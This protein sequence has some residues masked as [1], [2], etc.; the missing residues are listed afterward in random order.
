MKQNSEIGI[1]SILRQ[2]IS[3]VV[4]AVTTVLFLVFGSSWLSGLG[5]NLFSV[6]LFVWIFSVMLWS[7]FSVVRHADFL[8]I[9]LGEPYGTL[10][11]TISVISIEVIMISSIMLTGENN[12]TVG[13]DMMFGVFMI[14]LNA[15]IGLSLLVGGIRHIEQSY[16]FQGANTFLA[17]LIP[18]AVL[19]LILPNYTTPEGTG[20]FSKIQMVFIS[21][22][23]LGLYGAFLIIQ[24]MRHS[25]FFISADDNCTS[26]YEAED[27]HDGA[28][29]SVPYHACFLILNMLPIILLSKKLAVIIDF[30]F[31]EVGAPQA[32]GGVLVAVLVLTPECIAALSAAIRDK[33]QRSI[34]IGLGSA[35]ATIGLTVPAVLIIGLVTNK[36]VIIGLNPVN[37][38]LL[39]LTLLVS[40]VNFSSGRS[41]IIHGLIHLILF[42]AYIVLIF[43]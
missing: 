15:L 33:L 14:A 36:E 41:N 29:R 20:S 12:P 26:Q 25:K 7:S 18:L 3:L 24:T 1:G 42:L 38:V 11:L 43:D 34:N 5:S 10:I 13:R 28:I 6:I 8:A 37:S 35:L 23:T 9:K 21:L 16:N 4:S 17:V 22:G 27:H 32:L 39:V 31:A 19:G 30:G 2:E 40:I